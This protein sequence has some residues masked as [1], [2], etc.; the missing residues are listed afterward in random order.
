MIRN[1]HFDAGGASHILG[2]EK[3]R[4]LR[5]ESQKKNGRSRFGQ[6]WMKSLGGF[7][8]E[9]FISKYWFSSTH[10]T[11]NGGLSRRNECPT[12]DCPTY[13]RRRAKLLWKV[14]GN[15]ELYWDIYLIRTINLWLVF[16]VVWIKQQSCGVFPT[17]GISGKRLPSLSISLDAVI[18]RL[19]GLN[20]K[21]E[22]ANLPW[23]WSELSENSQFRRFSISP[24]FCLA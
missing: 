1:G 5:I 16:L 15:L 9:G 11:K 13:T 4:L 17:K 21:L 12:S 3:W 8:D 7:Y 18:E 22:R 14:L 23:F 20:S 6:G 19:R 2:L 10:D 24:Y